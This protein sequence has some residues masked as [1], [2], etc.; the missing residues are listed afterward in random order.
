MSEIKKTPVVKLFIGLIF[1]EELIYNKTRLLLEKQFGKVDF[2]SQA[3]DFSHTNYYEN[4][5]GTNL[6]KKFISF[7]KL[8]PADN[9]AQIK[10]ITN[11]IEKK[12][13]KNNKRLINI[14]P[15][16]ISLPKVVLASAKDFSHRIYLK[17]GI[18]AEITLLYQN[19]TFRHLEWTFPD[20][21]TEV[22][23]KILNQIREIFQKQLKSE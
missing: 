23:F 10:I 1:K 21:R 8:I 12:F 3:I 13:S 18:F 2:E 22:Y 17:K 11:K 14:D 20:F 19:N 9:L 6:K 5:I 16:Y 7:K 15:G 4:E